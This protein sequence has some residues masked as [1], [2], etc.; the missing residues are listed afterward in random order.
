MLVLQIVSIVFYLFSINAVAFVPT[1]CNQRTSSS[2]GQT[3]TTTITK[4][5]YNNILTDSRAR[6][7]HHGRDFSRH[8]VVASATKLKY[9]DD[10]NLMTNSTL[11][12]S[13][14][15]E[16][17]FPGAQVLTIE[18]AEHVPLGCTVEESLHKD[19]DVIFISKLTQE[20]HAEKARLQVGDVIVGVTGL[21]GQMTSTIDTDIEKIKKM[22]SAVL[23]EDPLTIQ[24]ARGT[25]I[26]ERHESA[27]VDLCNM[28][29]TNDKD[30]EDCVVNYIAGGYDYDTVDDNDVVDESLCQNDEETECLIDGMMN[31]W[32]D[33]LP[34]PSTTSG[35][36]DQTSNPSTAK[37]P[38]P[39]SSRSSGSGTWVR[40]PKTGNMRNIDK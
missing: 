8:Y 4:A 39:W 12:S 18:M 29:G 35:I 5:S 11:E 23:D 6:L 31:L 32:A 26:L 24:V 1:A 28:S 38:K 36:T 30:V 3:T 19:D 33:E 16:S 2:W 27:V 13:S 21:F 25:N 40:D 14:R 17:L 10:E 7:D 15:V 20:G 37:K 22:V 34:L 9:S